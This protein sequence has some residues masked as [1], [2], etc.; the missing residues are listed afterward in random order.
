MEAATSPRVSQRQWQRD[1][2]IGIIERAALPLLLRNGYEATTAEHLAD[3]AGVSVRTLFRYFPSG[4]DDVILAELRRSLDAL[5]ELIRSQP[6]GLTLLEVLDGARREWLALTVEAD[7]VGAARLT[8]DIARHQPNLVA[9]LVGERQLFAERM[10][11]EFAARLGLDATDDMRP[12]L[13]A[14]CYVSA[15]LSGY[16]ASLESSAI[17]PRAQVDEA[18]ELIRPLLAS[19]DGSDS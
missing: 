17:T 6:A 4:K 13:F 15:L 10:V 9:R 8:S 19:A 5:E 7:S 3:A 12:R 11:D 18:L 1:E 2:T 14:H 16:F